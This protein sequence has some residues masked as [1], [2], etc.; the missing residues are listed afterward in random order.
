[1]GFGE[2]LSTFLM[3]RIPIRIRIAMQITAYDSL[4]LIPLRDLHSF[5]MLF[6]T[7]PRVIAYEVDE[8]CSVQQQLRHDGI[9]VVCR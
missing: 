2:F 5:D 9:V 3:I 7:N 6:F 4:R 1:M 8:T